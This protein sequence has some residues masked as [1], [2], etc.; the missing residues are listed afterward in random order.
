MSLARVNPNL[1]VYRNNVSAKQDRTTSYLSIIKK[2]TIRISYKR[3]SKLRR[4]NK[5]FYTNQLLNLAKGQS[6]FVKIVSIIEKHRNSKKTVF[7]QNKQQTKSSMNV[8]IC[9]NNVWS[10][11]ISD[12]QELWVDFFRFGCRSK[13]IKL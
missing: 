2:S 4:W 3:K 5:S 7:Q 6:T 12:V 9:E 10:D 1:V 8:L 13:S 11:I